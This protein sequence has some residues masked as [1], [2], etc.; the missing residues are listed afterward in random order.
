MG[1]K[2]KV[3][4][5]FVSIQGEARFAGIPS[6]FLRTFGCNF[7]CDGFGMPKGEKSTERF[8]IIPTEYVDYLDLPLVHTG[9]DSYASHDVRFKNLSPL[10]DVVDLAPEL[11][12]LIPTK[13]WGSVNN[14]VH[15]VITGGEPL[16]GWQRA[17]PELLRQPAMIGIK[18]ITFETNGT[19]E[20]QQELVEFFN[21]ER[22]DIH[23][24]FSVSAKL[25]SSGELWEDAIQPDVV[26][27]YNAI[28]NSLV[29][30]KFVVSHADDVIDVDR[31]VAAYDAY[32]KN[33]PIYIMPAG[34]TDQLY[35][36]NT[37]WV[38]DLAVQRGWRYSPRL[39]VDIWKNAWNT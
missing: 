20:I 3:A 5:K 23:V 16:L 7:T 30:L 35:F 17:Y 37:R 33:M 32:N 9:C 34:G 14:D 28:N 24:T 15:L 6:V 21:S 36:Q 25:T 10:Y 18:N 22:P 27:G 39:Q 29:Y 2:I 12:N 13:S 38:A 1:K 19:Q 26:N 8:N 11:L 31:A 4:E